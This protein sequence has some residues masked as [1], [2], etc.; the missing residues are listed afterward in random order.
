MKKIK[1]SPL[2]KMAEKALKSA[3]AKVVEEHRQRNLPLIIWKDGR[4][5]KISA[6]QL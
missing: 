1:R 5:V 3:V 2:V 4:I 6:S